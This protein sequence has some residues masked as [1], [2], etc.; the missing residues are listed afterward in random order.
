MS[1]LSKE[2]LAH[3]KKRRLQDAKP[4][5][6]DELARIS[7]NARDYLLTRH[8][9]ARRIE[10]NHLSTFISQL[11]ALASRLKN[12]SSTL[13]MIG[14]SPNGQ[15]II[16]Q[17]RLGSK[18][19]EFL[20]HDFRLVRTEYPI[21]RFSPVY[22]V[23][24]R[25]ARRARPVISWDAED[26]AG[27]PGQMLYPRFA[28]GVGHYASSTLLYSSEN[29]ELVIRV[30]NRMVRYLR[31]KLTSKE[32]N[33][34]YSN[35]RRAATENYNNLTDGLRRVVRAEKQ[36]VGLRIDLHLNRIG[37]TFTAEGL[38]IEAT[39]RDEMEKLRTVFH[40][41]MRR[42]FGNSIRGWASC[43]EFG[44][45]RGWHTHYLILLAARPSPGDDVELVEALGKQWEKISSC[46]DSFYNV[47]VDKS[48]HEYLAVG[49][50]DS[51]S[52]LAQMGL[53]L[54]A[55][56]FTLANLWVQL[57]L[58]PGLKTFGH[59]KFPKPDASRDVEN[60]LGPKSPLWLTSG[61]A[62]KIVRFI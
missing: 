23:F 44:A 62:R 27:S 35:F 49:V 36:L 16:K 14:L 24:E 28:P 4:A 5:D 37:G 13:F 12:S 29:A 8:N 9:G 25:L 30:L 50:F 2:H 17:T 41:F 20:T 40:A 15:S 45:L 53:L 34:S 7:L 61:E 22:L 39:R 60:K 31:R 11:H 56:Y 46:T 21:H 55:N 6:P 32:V 51:R 3:A 43:T 47:N 18:L 54:T 1:A 48:K 26:P 42:K 10:I 33:E 19:I 58:P 38:R 59:G 52:R 57:D